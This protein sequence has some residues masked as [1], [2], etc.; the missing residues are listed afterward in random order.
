MFNNFFVGNR[1][2]H[3]HIERDLGDAGHFHDAFVA[4]FGLKVG[5]D[6]AVVE[7]L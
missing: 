6:L 5:N 7:L 1:F 2:R 3:T 4:K